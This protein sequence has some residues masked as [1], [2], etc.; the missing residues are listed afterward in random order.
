MSENSNTNGSENNTTNNNASSTRTNDVND[1]NY[2]NG[3]DIDDPSN[4]NC[5]DCVDA[6]NNT[7]STTKSIRKEAVTEAYDIITAV[8]ENL[9]EAYEY[10]R[11]K[12]TNFVFEGGG[13]RGIAFGGAIHYLEKHDLMKQITRFGGSSAGSIVSAALAV[14][15]SG[16][17]I[18][19]IL[20]DTDFKTFED[21]SWGPFG[22]VYRMVTK[23]G[24]YKGEA[25]EKW[26]EGILEK[27]TGDPNI[28]FLEVYKTYGKELVITGTC[29]NTCDTHYYHHSTYPHMPIKKAVRISMSIPVFFAS[30][31]E[32]RNVMVDGGLL[33][34]YPIWVFDGNKIGD[35]HV[36]DE[37]IAKSKT[38]GFKLMTDQE[39]QDYQLY[40][41]DEPVDNIYQYFTAL[42]NSMLIQIERSHIRS[43]YW[44]RTVCI[45]THN[46]SSIEFSLPDET[47]QKLIQTGYDSI[48]AKL[49]EI[50][51]KL[52]ENIE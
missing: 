9:T 34:N 29:L 44:N 7:D 21:D 26:F 49:Q 43:G 36:T 28:T 8:D 50:Q 1:V 46:V 37:Q 13:I 27:K 41:V 35:P 32:G 12:F 51:R 5:G 6:T 30:V 15:Y 31:K 48:H 18:I 16:P 42:I 23:F 40:H 25:F 52:L 11:N 33:N 14:G 4:G 47:K 19:K 10:F 38:V 45:D 17:E 3:V 2:V 24:V 22:D 20:H 39:K